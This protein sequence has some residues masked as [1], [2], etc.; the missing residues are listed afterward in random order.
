MGRADQAIKVR[1][2]FVQPAQVA[3]VLKRHGEIARAR[4]VV[5]RQG[6]N[7]VMTLKCETAG[8]GTGLS[9]AVGETLQAA[10]KVKGGGAGRAR[11]PPQRRQG[12]RRP[13]PLRLTAVR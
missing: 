1:G 6:D 10:C 3:A 5:T 11:Q 13:A 4:L 9:A 7:D 12:D 2:M 8:S